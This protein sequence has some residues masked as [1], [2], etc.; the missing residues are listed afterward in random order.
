MKILHR[1]GKVEEADT[2]PVDTVK[3][4]WRV[5]LLM[6][7]EHYPVTVAQCDPRCIEVDGGYR[8]IASGVEAIWLFW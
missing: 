4:G 8:Y 3:T 7:G 6:D 2:F 5:T 1:D